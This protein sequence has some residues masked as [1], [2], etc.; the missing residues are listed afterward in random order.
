MTIRICITALLAGLLLL[1][2]SAHAAAPRRWAVVIGVDRYANGGIAPLEYAVADA[3]SLAETLRSTG[4]FAADD[5]FELTSDRAGEEAPTRTN[6]A[7]R[8]DYLARQMK[9]GDELV[10][11]FSGHGLEMDGETFL[12]TQEADPRSRLTLQQSALQPR[13]LFRWVQATRAGKVLLVVDACRNEPAMSR[14]M[15]DNALTPG[16][17]RDLALVSTGGGAA[18]GPTATATLFACSSGQR[19]YEWRDRG[20][21][22]FTYFLVEGLRGGAADAAGHVTL[23]GLVDYVQRETAR[24]SERW[25]LHR[26]EPWLRYEGPG[27]HLWVLR[28]GAPEVAAAPPAPSAPVPDVPAPVAVA[29]PA[30]SAPAPSAPAPVAVAPTSAPPA[31]LYVSRQ[32]GDTP[33][34]TIGH[35]VQEAPP[36][37]RIVIR[38]GV[39]NEAV[40]LRKP[41]ELVGEDGAVIRTTSPHAVEVRT[42]GAVRLQGLRL[43]C[44]DPSQAVLGHA[45][46]EDVEVASCETRRVDQPRGGGFRIQFGRGGCR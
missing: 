7:F 14:G 16:L 32:G 18:A 28:E 42:D 34:R 37:S 43:E 40:V 33:Y 8:F 12:L 17:A 44:G 13:D 35:A 10:V 21:G 23:A 4:A 20:H 25:T 1:T 19:S 15:G 27:A 36:G 45:L 26:Q 39:Y 31:T 2:S 3:R 24:A 9:P 6:V 46:R 5:V 29:P 11:F 30:P 38:E 22:F 41:V